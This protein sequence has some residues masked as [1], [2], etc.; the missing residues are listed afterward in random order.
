MDLVE[1]GG[2][3]ASSLVLLYF[4]YFFDFNL[5]SPLRTIASVSSLS[6]SLCTYA[7][8]HSFKPSF[9]RWNPPVPIAHPYL[10]CIVLASYLRFWW[11]SIISLF[12]LLLLLLYHRT[13]FLSGCM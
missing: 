12:L 5:E 7:L 8:S 1:T 6:T 9:Q 10:C 3:M 4:L 2:R 11:L 13:P